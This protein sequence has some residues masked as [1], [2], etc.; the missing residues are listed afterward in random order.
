TDV[1]PGT[2]DSIRI[3]A[4]PTN[5]TSITV[6]ATTYTSATFPAGGITLAAPGAVPAQTITVDPV[7]GP[8][9]VGITF[10]V[11]DNA[12]KQSATTATLTVPFTSASIA[13]Q[14]FN[15]A[16]GQFGTPANTIDG[17]GSNAG[18]GLRAV[19][20]DG[21]GNVVAFATVPTT[22]LYSF[23]D[24]AAGTYS[25]RLTTTIPTVGAPAP[26]ASL[27]AGWANSAEFL[28]TGAGND[29]TVD[30]ILGNIVVA[31][32][33]VTNA[34]FGIEQLP[35][36]GTATAATQPN[37]GGTNNS[38]SITGFIGTDVAPGA[39]DSIRIT[40][41]PT[42]ITSITVGTTTYTTATFPAGG[43]AIAAPGAV[44]AQTILVD[45][46]SGPV[47][48]VITYV[49]ID[50]AGKQ[51][52]ATGT[53]TVPF[54]SASVSGI[55]YNDA[56]GQLG[57]PSNT[58]DGTPTNAGG[59][60][61]VLVNG[62]GN[63]VAVTAVDASGAYTF[64]DL[65][66][67]TYSV[68]ITTNTATVGAPAPAVVLPAGWVSTSEF[69]GAGEGNDGAANGIIN[70]VTVATTSV[71]NA[72]FGIERAPLATPA[73]TS[74]PMPVIGTLY[75]L[76]GQGANP[77]VPAANDAEDGVLGAGK[78]IV[79]STLPANT[80]LL[81]NGNPATVGQVIPN[82]N[83][84]LMQVQVTTA[85]NGTNSTSFTFAYVDAAGIQ[86]LTPA[87]Y[88]LNWGVNLP[89]KISAFT[90][91]ID[92]ATTRL[93]WTTLMELNNQGFAIERS[94]N[95]RDWK[96]IGFVNSFADQGNSNEQLDY[97]SYDRKP[98]SGINYYRL[99]QVD[100]DGKFYYSE[101]R[102]VTFGDAKDRITIYPNPAVDRVH[103]VVEDWDEIQE[104]RLTDTH[105][106]VIFKAKEAS[107]GIDI[108]AVSQGMY[109]LQVEQ[110]NG[111]VLSF[112]VIKK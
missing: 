73:T 9:S 100:L 36:A 75:T 21:A 44:P 86:S 51:S 70:G 65:A 62:A 48:V 25:V 46:V 105:G 47:S 5:I 19:L 12:G 53:L 50:N 6:G 89:V 42:N 54:T 8:V 4:F 67:G 13:G 2:V 71:I 103:I 63:V 61:A 94:A 58:I 3:T 87:T 69:L 102:K 59:L 10:A 81:Y 97:T 66:G 1:A 57:S 26:A 34:N 111:Q 41:F 7:N 39:V 64:A 24:L 104:V 79:V 109:L 55:V 23:V 38:T 74:V 92:G 17:T 56:N 15:D 88:T 83:P 52:A 33:A 95:S 28:G 32:T 16:N 60:N 107:A 18:G 45:P 91:T 43:I 90:A 29:G 37:P 112:K 77:P 35:T 80:T 106:K 30:G 110:T 76:D 22:G 49:V 93:D 98:M 99:K 40:A 20:V 108:T 68:R 101:I 72:N 84:S 85:T 78:T 31:T 82:F 96:E 14:V 27:P 11:I